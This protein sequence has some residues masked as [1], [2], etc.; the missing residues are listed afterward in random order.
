MKLFTSFLAALLALAATAAPMASA[1]AEAGCTLTGT[2]VKGTD[3]SSCSAVVINSLSVPAG[4][5]LDLTKTKAG[6]SIT[7]EGTTT[8][9]TAKWEGPLV[10]LT[11][12]NLKVGGTGTLDGQGSWYWKQGTSISRPVFFRLSKVTGSTLSGFTIKNSPFRTFSILSSTSTTLSGLTI[13]SSAGNSLA[14]NT[15]GFDLSKNDHVTITGCKVYNQDDCLAMQSSTN[16]VFSGNTCSGGH[17]ISIGSLGGTTTDASDT[18]NGLTVYNN[19]IIDSVNGIRIK[20][21]ID[22]EGLVQNANYTSNT[23]TNVKNA[24][25]VHSDYSKSKGGY[26]GSPTSKVKITGVTINGLTGSATNVYDIVAN[27][28]VVSNWKFSGVSVSGKT[29]SCSGQPSTVKCA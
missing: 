27:P 8:F 22:L 26:T 6:A 3:I 20:T 15:D 9:G 16:T 14:K 13:D 24:I 1:E 18:V 28:S 29:G 23:L 4:V 21:I 25:V 11:G 19:K 12:S 5:T 7:F 17:G 2:Y 10:L